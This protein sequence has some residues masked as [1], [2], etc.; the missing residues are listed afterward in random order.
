MQNDLSL[1]A[2]LNIVIADTR[3]SSFISRLTLEQIYLKYIFEEREGVKSMEER[4]YNK[5]IFHI[6][7]FF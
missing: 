7:F 1:N 3:T 4:Q 2:I 6:M 5:V